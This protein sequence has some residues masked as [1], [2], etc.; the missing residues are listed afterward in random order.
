MPFESILAECVF[1]GNAMLTV[2]GCT[3]YN[4][5]YGRVPNILPGIDQVTSPGETKVSI[6]VTIAHSHRLREVCIQAIIEGSARARLGRALNT[7]SLPAA[8]AMNLQVGEE[9]D[10]YR[11]P[12]QKDASGWFG[13]ATLTDVS[14][15]SRGMVT[16][17]W[18]SRP[19]EVRLQDVRRHLYF[20]A[21]LAGPD[22]ISL[23]G[24]VWSYIRSSLE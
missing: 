3:P 15:T 8:Q 17:R 23:A 12:S 9:V 20:L 1:A 11:Q 13:P 6:P 14:Q 5:V 24:I 22:T 21:L 18:L 7:R 10:F 16:V 19:M 2:N 4:A